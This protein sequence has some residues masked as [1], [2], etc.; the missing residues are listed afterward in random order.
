MKIASTFRE[1]VSNAIANQS[2]EWLCNTPF[3]ATKI[4]ARYQNDQIATLIIKNRCNLI[5]YY[6][7][8]IVINLN[9][10]M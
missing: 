5:I 4:Y 7:V 2:C 3:I 8:L 9:I 6:V 10:Q 1:V